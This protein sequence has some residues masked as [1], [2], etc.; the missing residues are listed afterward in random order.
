MI[1]WKLVAFSWIFEMFM[2]QKITLLLLAKTN[3]KIKF[4]GIRL[5]AD[6]FWEYLERKKQK[7]YNNR[8]TLLQ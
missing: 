2:L 6:V 4:N 1:G 8:D 5:N 7:C 3:E